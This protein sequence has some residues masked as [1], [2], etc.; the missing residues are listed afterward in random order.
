MD[1]GR[2]KLPCH[3]SDKSDI[4][5]EEQRGKYGRRPDH[6]HDG[7]RPPD[8]KF[9]REGPIPDEHADMIHTDRRYRLGFRWCRDFVNLCQHSLTRRQPLNRVDRMGRSW[10]NARFGSMRMAFKMAY[11]PKP[12]SK[13]CRPCR[14]RLP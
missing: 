8:R 5:R 13:F 10:V 12:T 4:R 1:D 14:Y 11:V 7:G 9:S 6:L 3:P 2:I